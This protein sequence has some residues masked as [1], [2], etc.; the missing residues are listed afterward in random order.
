M[1]GTKFID[2][3]SGIVNRGCPDLV[4]DTGEVHNVKERRANFKK[5]LTLLGLNPQ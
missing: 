5:V 1:K 3:V 4:C 2:D